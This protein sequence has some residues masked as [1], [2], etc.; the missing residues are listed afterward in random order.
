MPRTS[1][2][3]FGLRRSLF[4]Y[5]NSQSTSMSL[6]LSSISE[7]SGATSSTSDNVTS[8]NGSVAQEAVR[9]CWMD[10]RRSCPVWQGW[11]SLRQW[12]WSSSDP[13]GATVSAQLLKER[14]I[15]SLSRVCQASRTHLT[16]S[17]RGGP[18]MFPAAVNEWA[19][20]AIHASYFSVTLAL[21]G[22]FHATSGAWIYSV[23]P[24]GTM[25]GSIFACASCCLM[26]SVMWHLRVLSQHPTS[27]W[28][29]A[30]Y[31]LHLV[32][33]QVFIHPSV[34]IRGYIALI[35][36]LLIKLLCF[37]SLA[38]DVLSVCIVVAS[39]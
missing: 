9:A 10:A 33:S 7:L 16:I 17:G 19:P 37:C 12:I 5:H 22:I 2:S 27:K 30:Q 28:E 6:S 1:N 23:Q 38:N 18:R 25:T 35:F 15:N 39:I 32:T 21:K 24:P 13:S 8:A 4:C 11:P 34:Y 26:L 31:S 29:L 36:K 3:L 20:S 14:I